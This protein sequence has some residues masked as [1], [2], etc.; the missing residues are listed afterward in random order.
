MR[1]I[2]SV[3]M[4][5]GALAVTATLIAAP[6]AQAGPV[7]NELD[8]R[9]PCIRSNDI[10]SNIALGGPTGDARLRLRNEDGANAVDLQAST[11]NLTNLFSNEADQSNGLVKAWARI[12]VNGT[13]LACWRCNKDP[14][15][16]G[17]L[18]TGNY[19]VDFTPLST[20]IR[21]RPRA[22][23]ADA[24]S[25]Q[26]VAVLQSYDRS[27]DASSVRVLAVAPSTGNLV[28]TVF[29]LLIY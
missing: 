20:D 23:T 27:D 16:T 2:S 15:E 7:C 28:D 14:S 9:S 8:L 6:P 25:Q 24:H 13:I 11:G 26:N 5:T 17:R 22:V 19:V 10:R 1:I 29:T 3:I 21:G 4:I 18:G 12:N